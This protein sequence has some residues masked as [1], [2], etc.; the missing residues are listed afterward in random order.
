M[1][2]YEVM[3]DRERIAEKFN[4][5][6]ESVVFHGSCLDLMKDIPDHYVT[7]KGKLLYSPVEMNKECDVGNHT[8][9]CA[10]FLG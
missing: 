1:R 9:V 6:A 4:R 8:L 7:M 10:F 3:S 5:E 2:Y